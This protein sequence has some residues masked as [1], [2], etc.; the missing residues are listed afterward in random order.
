[1]QPA[2]TASLLVAGMQAI[3]GRESVIENLTLN[4]LTT[5]MQRLMRNTTPLTRMRRRQFRRF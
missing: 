2:P 3:V 1:M 5:A 4:F